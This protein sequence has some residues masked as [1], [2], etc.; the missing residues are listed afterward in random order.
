MKINIS[1]IEKETQISGVDTS[2][3]TSV[4]GGGFQLDVQANSI[5]IANFSGSIAAQADRV[6]DISEVEGNLTFGDDGSIASNTAAS[7]QGGLS[8]A[9]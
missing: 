1:T 8:I 9:S 6:W 2:V 3:A 5:G 7:W 4:I